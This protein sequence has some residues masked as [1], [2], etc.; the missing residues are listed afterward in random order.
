MNDPKVSVCVPTY[1]GARYIIDCFESILAQTWQDFEIVVV[2]DGSSD[3]TVKICS[4]FARRDPRI[5]VERN[6]HNLGLVGNWQRCVELARAP[7]IK[8]VFQDDTLRP[9]GLAVL[10]AAAISG[11][12]APLV[13]GRRG[14]IF[15][16]GTTATTA[17]VYELGARG[18]AQLFPEDGNMDAQHFS[19]IVLANLTTNI[20]GE[21]VAVLFRRDMIDAVGSFHPDVAIFCDMEFWARVGTRFGVAHISDTVADFR[22]HG[23][24]TT[25]RTMSADHFQLS[26]LDHVIVQHEMAFAPVYAPLRQ[27]AAIEGIDLSERFAATAIWARGQARRLAGEPH[28]AASKPLQQ[29]ERMQVRYPRLRDVLK[30]AQRQ[31]DLGQ[32]VGRLKRAISGRSS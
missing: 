15:E 24:S 4:D 26:A 9:D 2:D 28:G 30:R 29:L 19:R 22:V 18:V 1:N 27:V 25:A 32:L 6:Q 17:E 13:F 31:H 16:A 3:A 5:R 21:P 23:E 20:V 8:F 11:N 10:M 12:G 14:F 7:W